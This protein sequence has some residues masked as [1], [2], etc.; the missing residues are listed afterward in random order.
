[1]D[2]K[3]LYPSIIRTFKVDPYARIVAKQQQRGDIILGFNG[4]SFSKQENILP[5]IIEELWQAR[6]NAKKQGN[7]A[8]SQAIKIIMNSFYG[9]LGTPGCRVHDAR[10]TS[11]ITLRGHELIKHTVALIQQEGY[12]VIYG[13][14][15]S[16][17]VSLSQQLDND[18]AD[19]IGRQLVTK[20]N[21]YWQQRLQLDY[22]IESHL[23]MEY[24]THFKRFFMPTVR[25]SDKGSKKRYA[26]MVNKNGEERI[27]FK[28]LET[29]RTDWTPL[30]RQFQQQLYQKIFHDQPY[31]AYIRLIVHEL[32]SG[33][34]DAQLVY[35]KRLRQNLGDYQKNIP[36]H[37]RAALL[38]EQFFKDNKQ[39][40]RYRNKGWIEYVMTVNGPE[41]LEC[42]NSAL[43]YEHY[44][45]K[46]LMPIA[47]NI[48]HILG[49]SMQPIIQDQYQLF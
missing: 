43:D 39:P 6:D 31:E 10:L 19:Q 7:K 42:Q 21:A 8:L 2:Y 14:T 44:I 34:L 25:G 18:A 3:S 32:K 17:F 48:L 29:V 5:G 41:T 11:S 37:V 26:G 28:G 33:K 35:R 20:I 12:S 38:A 27:I 40:S 15:D 36:P 22:G 4:A 24:E 47:D 1:L 9:V 16:V 30:A 13:D 23:E 49:T 46:Q 45:D